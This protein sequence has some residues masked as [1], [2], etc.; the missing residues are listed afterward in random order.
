MSKDA[1]APNLPPTLPTPKW[2]EI[3]NALSSFQPM[4]QMLRVMLAKEMSKDAPQLPPSTL[5]LSY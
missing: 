3:M 1:P 5:S 4:V 2:P